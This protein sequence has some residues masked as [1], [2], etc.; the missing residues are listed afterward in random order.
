MKT[1]TFS[2]VFL[3]LLLLFA[4]GAAVISPY[5][6]Y[7][8]DLNNRFLAPLSPE[9]LLGT[10]SLGRD[11][12]SR[13]IYGARS[14]FIVGIVS[15]LV[16]FIVGT[17]IGLAAVYGP[18]WLHTVLMLSMDSLLAIP[19]IL[20]SI[21]VMAV[22]GYGLVQVM[23]ALGIVFSPLIARLMTAEVQKAIRED[24]VEIETLF[25]TP[26]L[27]VFSAAILPQV[28]PPLLVQLTSLFAVAISIE[29]SLSFL[30]IGIQPPQASWGIMLDEART[31]LL[32]DPWMILPP[33]IALALTVYSLNTI[34]DFVNRKHLQKS[35]NSAAI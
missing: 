35:L 10:D 32:S 25:N 1:V 31:Y 22:F 34:A 2:Y 23:Y 7:E 12:L 27:R 19:A 9:H 16:A 30:G 28:L 20:M 8:Q 33:G 13:L 26:R 24:Y 3:V 18:P 15:C 4:L 11:I 5:E 17:A 6:P 21:A 29:A 14:T